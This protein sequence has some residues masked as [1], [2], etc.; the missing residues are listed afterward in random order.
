MDGEGYSHKLETII[1]RCYGSF[2]GEYI[3]IDSCFFCFYSKVHLFVAYSSEKI[4]NSLKNSPNLQMMKCRLVGRL[5]IE[6]SEIAFIEHNCVSNE[7]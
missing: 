5:L 6:N 1:F 4:I 7:N 2:P 3:V